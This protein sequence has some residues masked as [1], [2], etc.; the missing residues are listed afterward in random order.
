MVNGN[1]RNKYRIW[2]CFWPKNIFLKYCYILSNT[3]YIRVLQG[4]YTV[5]DFCTFLWFRYCSYALWSCYTRPSP[6]FSLLVTIP[7]LFWQYLLFY[8]FNVFMLYKLS[9]LYVLYWFLLIHSFRSCHSLSG[10]SSFCKV[11]I[12]IAHFIK[13][14]TD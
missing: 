11:S 13:T 5:F 12:A 14:K 2:S 3:L 10:L 7:E 9:L 6:L 8:A 1:N 4:L